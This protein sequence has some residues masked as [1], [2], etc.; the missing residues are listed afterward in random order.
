[1][2]YGDSNGHVTDDLTWPRKV[3][4][5]APIYLGPII[6]RTAGDTPRHVTPKGQVMTPI[7]LG[8]IISTTVGDMYVFKM[9]LISKPETVR[10]LVYCSP[11]YQIKYY[12]H[13]WNLICTTTSTWSLFSVGRLL[14]LTSH[15]NSTA[16]H[17]L[18]PQRFWALSKVCEVHLTYDSQVGSR[19][20]S[21]ECISY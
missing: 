4:F 9:Q 18:A 3:Q 16:L 21:G 11:S 13:P 5:I 1:M 10:L 17:F 20:R 8:L 12:R 7:C 14:S 15:H 19:L 2:A 6:S